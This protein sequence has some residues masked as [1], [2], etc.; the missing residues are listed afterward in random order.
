MSVPVNRDLYRISDYCKL[1]ILCGIIS[2]PYPFLEIEAARDA[3]VRIFYKILF[4]KVELDRDFSRRGIKVI[5]TDLL[6]AASARVYGLVADSRTLY[7]VVLALLIQIKHYLVIVL[8]LD[9]LHIGCSEVKISRQVSM[10]LFQR[11]L[12]LVSVKIDRYIVNSRNSTARGVSYHQRVSRR[13]G[14]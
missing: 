14:A 3:S 12:N 5:G 2:V 10:I 13:L 4:G 9:L 11:V 1:L 7:R 6:L 8:L